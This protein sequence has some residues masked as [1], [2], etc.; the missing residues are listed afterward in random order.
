MPPIIY[1]EDDEQTHKLYQK[2]IKT[3]SSKHSR[4][5]IRS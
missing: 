1:G 2:S 4:A 5:I 3:D